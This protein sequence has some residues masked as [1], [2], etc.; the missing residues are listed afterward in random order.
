MSDLIFP[1]FPGITIDITR[2]PEWNTV[3]KEAW[4]GVETRIGQRAWPRWRYTLK[5]DVLRATD[6]EIG[7]LE[8][9]FNRHAGMVESFLFR[10]PENYRVTDQAFGVC[11]GA[12]TLFQ[13]NR[14]VGTWLEPVWAPS[15]SPAPV[16][17]RNGVAL[18]PVTDYTLGTRGQVQLTSAPPSGTLTWSG[19]Y[20]LRCRFGEDKLQLQRILL[21]LW[22][23]GKVE[24][25]SEV[26]PS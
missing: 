8:A 7:A 18:V 26:F 22:K 6:G 10:D 4:S 24:L 2:Q 5:I 19:E 3:I 23:V 12:A 17:K 20:Y 11:D 16:I 25:V 1:D 13:L 14:P 21:G 15:S 9:F